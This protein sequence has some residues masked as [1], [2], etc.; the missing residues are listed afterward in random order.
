MRPVGERDLTSPSF[1]DVVRFE[2]RQVPEMADVHGLVRR[3]ASPYDA[4]VSAADDRYTEGGC[5]G[6][7]PAT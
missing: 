5:C 1:E 4:A 6:D 3:V 7:A 2:G